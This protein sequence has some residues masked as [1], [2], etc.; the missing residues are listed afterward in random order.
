M[1]KIS[2]LP[3]YL[4]ILFQFFYLIRINEAEVVTVKPIR[5]Y[6]DYGVCSRE[7]FFIF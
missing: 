5:N 6:S 7:Y 2:K 3:F 4:F 1:K